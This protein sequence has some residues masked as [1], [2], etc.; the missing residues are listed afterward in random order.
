MQLGGFLAFIFAVLIVPGP[1][2]MFIVTNAVTRG[3]RYGISAFA[4]VFLI[5]VVW[6]AVSWSTLFLIFSINGGL[7]FYLQIVGVAIIFWI[8]LEFIFSKVHTDTPA[9]NKS[10]A[11]VF[12]QGL[13]IEGFSPAPF[14]V[15][16]TIYS[17]F[18]GAIALDLFVVMFVC[19][20]VLAAILFA[21]ISVAIQFLHD[22][23]IVFDKF[24]SVARITGGFAIIGFGVVVAFSLLQQL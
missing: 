21:V 22:R 9:S 10:L 1:L 2:M 6:A 18:A 4:G 3:W 8:G 24:N 14:F 19:Q 13:A 23:Y 17:T 5:N 7:L 16:T 11:K 15:Y 20:M 12:S